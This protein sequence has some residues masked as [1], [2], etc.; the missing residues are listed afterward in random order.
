MAKVI[1][2]TEKLDFGG[3]PKIKVKDIEIEVNDDAPTMLKVMGIL[4]DND[5]PGAKEVLEMYNL[6]F[7]EK[8]RKKIDDMKL[9]FK[10]FSTVVFT[11]INL[12]NGEDDSSGEQ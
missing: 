1:D 7:D 10:S 5:E 6:I 3:H 2:I 9:N 11:A 8:E 12:V 4:G